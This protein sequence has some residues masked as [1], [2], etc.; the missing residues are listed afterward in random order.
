MADNSSKKHSGGHVSTYAT[1]HA[2]A[3]WDESIEGYL[4]R[5]LILKENIPLA[6]A[7]TDKYLAV[8]DANKRFN[9]LFGTFP[10][11]YTNKHLAKVIKAPD[12]TAFLEKLVH[13]P[14]SPGVRKKYFIL[15]PKNKENNTSSRKPH[16]LEPGERLV[17]FYYYHLETGGFLFFFYEDHEQT[18]NLDIG[19][20]CFTLAEEIGRSVERVNYLASG[21]EDGCIALDHDDSQD[22]RATSARLSHVA[23]MLLRYADLQ[24][25][26]ACEFTT[27]SLSE[28]VELAR[29]KILG[30]FPDARIDIIKEIQPE[31]DQVLGSEPLLVELF[32]HLLHNAWKFSKSLGKS[33][34]FIQ[35]TRHD[36][37]NVIWFKDPGTGIDPAVADNV[38]MP[39]ILGPHVARDYGGIGLGLALVKRI[40]ELH[41][42]EIENDT[43][44]EQAASFQIRL[45]LAGQQQEN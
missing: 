30:R 20:I 9:S 39:F 7:A 1:R 3:S 31:A 10:S 44:Q 29:K 6:Y 25:T 33:Q 11:R 45:P 38:F 41:N 37:H 4:E 42:G 43:S 24:K 14:K 28:S 2:Q 5:F 19:H 36:G 15:S 32:V 40:V 34:V 13:S 27:V 18:S 26:N 16:E 17:R 22:M 21:Q 35:A 12:F 8:R 23:D